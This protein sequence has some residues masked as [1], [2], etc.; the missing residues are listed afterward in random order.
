M[1]NALLLMTISFGLL[2]GAACDRPGGDEP[3]AGDQAPER[4]GGSDEDAGVVD[5]TNVERVLCDAPREDAACGFTQDFSKCPED[6]P[7]SFSACGDAAKAQCS[8]CY[9]V[10]GKEFFDTWLCGSAGWLPLTQ[11]I[12]EICTTADGGG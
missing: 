12:D 9:S 2:I 3:D 11:Y 10:R 7:R 8:Y 4:D 1:R 6:V 5:T